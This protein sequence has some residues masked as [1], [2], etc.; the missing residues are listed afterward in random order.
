MRPSVAD[1]AVTR[2]KVVLATKVGFRSGSALMQSGLSRRHILWSVEQSLRRLGTDW[3]DVYIAHRED[4]DT[5]PEET[6][7]ALDVLVQAG[8][9][10]CLGFSNWSAWKVAAAIEIQR[11]AGLAAFTHRCTTRCSGAMWNPT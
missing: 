8:K 6:L 3:I 5:L 4:P 10:R 11:A 9:V 1:C 2:A 7:A